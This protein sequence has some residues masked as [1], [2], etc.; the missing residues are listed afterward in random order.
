MELPLF[1]LADVEWVEW[2]EL[3]TLLPCENFKY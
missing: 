3:V 2:D 1:L